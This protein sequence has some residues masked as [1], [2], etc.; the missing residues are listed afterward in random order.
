MRTIVEYIINNHIIVDKDI[1]NDIVLT[2]ILNAVL[3]NLKDYLLSKDPLSEIKSNDTHKKLKDI[4][5]NDLRNILFC[6][7]NH[8]E[9]LLAC[10]SDEQQLDLFKKYLQE[11]L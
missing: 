2:Y 8:N 1:P 10:G 9:D 5:E 3:G 11:E 6:C 7:V 4:K